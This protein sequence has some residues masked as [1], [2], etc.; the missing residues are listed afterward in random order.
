M[1]IQFAKLAQV[2]RGKEQYGKP[3]AGGTPTGGLAQLTDALND[4]HDEP[5][6][7]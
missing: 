1:F 4:L 7:E 6:P 5:H 2:E 3:S